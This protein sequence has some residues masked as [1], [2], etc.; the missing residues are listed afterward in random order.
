[1]TTHVLKVIAASVCACAMFACAKT[2]TQPKEEKEMDA[3]K[4][5]KATSKT[6]EK[7]DW[8]ASF[9]TAFNVGDA[10]SIATMYS[11]NA[12][13]TM[14]NGAELKSAELATAL[15]GAFQKGA[16]SLETSNVREYPVGDG[17][18][19]RHDFSFAVGENTI[20]GVRTIWKSKEGVERDIWVPASQASADIFQA[21]KSETGK[22]DAWYNAAAAS[23][24]PY[25]P[26]TT[27][28]LTNGALF[29]GEVAVKFV[30]DAV[31]AISKM[32]QSVENAFV[33]G[34]THVVTE[35]TFSATMTTEGGPV[36]LSGRRLTLWSTAQSPWKV[37]TELSWP[38]KK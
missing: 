28:L 2:A 26:D 32:E 7:S 10:N 8:L 36:P 30:S 13:W 33:V 35:G 19:F 15:A 5:E 1:M 34:E 14:A 11:A 37:V 23:E 18:I 27:V 3:V 4:V 29:R 12:T 9:Q 16:G 17:S 22:L 21:A 24:S 38:E 25:T 31:P 6:A 20:S